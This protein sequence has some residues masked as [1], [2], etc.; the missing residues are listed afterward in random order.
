MSGQNE[1]STD[2]DG[3]TTTTSYYDSSGAKVVTV[4]SPSGEIIDT[5]VANPDGTT[6]NANRHADGSVARTTKR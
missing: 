4:Q 3:N 5:S 1:K 2:A 6:S